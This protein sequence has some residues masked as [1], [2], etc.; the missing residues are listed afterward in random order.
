MVQSVSQ[1]I[2]EL[3][4]QLLTTDAQNVASAGCIAPR[5]LFQKKKIV[6]LKLIIS[7]G[8]DVA[9]ALKNAQQKTL[10]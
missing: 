10:K 3:S 5:E 6:R 2:G 7:I 8:K 1:E 4:D 9:Y